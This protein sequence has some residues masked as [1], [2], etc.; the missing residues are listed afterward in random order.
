MNVQFSIFS[1]NFTCAHCRWAC[2]I[3]RSLWLPPLDPL[4]GS[5]CAVRIKIHPPLAMDW[6][7]LAM[8]KPAISGSPPLLSNWD[9]LP[10]FKFD[11]L[12]RRPLMN[13]AVPG[14][15]GISFFT[16]CNQCMSVHWLSQCWLNWFLNS[17]DKFKSNCSIYNNCK[18]GSWCL[19]SGIDSHHPV[20]Q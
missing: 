12:T 4:P 8:A 11:Q 14:T 20:A 3:L 15:S 19:K 1:N 17:F 2:R 6:A 5:E 18:R 7:C 9:C 13:L 16:I 10:L